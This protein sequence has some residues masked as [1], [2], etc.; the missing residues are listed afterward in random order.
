MVLLLVLL[1]FGFCSG[2]PREKLLVL[3][4]DL[5]N[6]QT[7]SKFFDS[8][9]ADQFELVFRRASDPA[10]VSLKQEN[11]SALLVFEV[12]A[13]SSFKARGVLNWAREENRGF[14]VAGMK[15]ALAVQLGASVGVRQV[16]GEALRDHMSHHDEL[17]CQVIEGRVVP[18]AQVVQHQDA[19]FYEGPALELTANAKCEMSGH[20]SAFVRNSQSTSSCFLASMWRSSLRAVFLGS[21]AMMANSRIDLPSSGRAFGNLAVLRR[22]VA[23]VAGRFNMVHGKKKKKKKEETCRFANLFF[24][25]SCSAFV[26]DAASGSKNPV[27]NGDAGEEDGSGRLDG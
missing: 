7:Y 20:S 19:F 1:M 8:L 15:S 23:W 22:C 13:E 2:W 18:S 27:C 3:V 24:E 12:A 9:Q 6:R 11:F 17:G 21:A 25:A 16:D 10:L 26:C 5:S 4:D 14:I